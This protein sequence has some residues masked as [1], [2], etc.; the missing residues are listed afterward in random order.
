MLAGVIMPLIWVC[1]GSSVFGVGWLQLAYPWNGLVAGD[2]KWLPLDSSRDAANVQAGSHGCEQLVWCLTVLN[3]LWSKGLA[4]LPSR[5]GSES[6]LVQM[7]GG[8][9]PQFSP[10]ALGLSCLTVY[11][12]TLVQS[13]SWIE[14]WTR[15][16]DAVAPYRR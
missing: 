8:T 16:R 1:W 3:S 14:V 9:Q 5:L 2:D 12:L 4:Y 10:R 13:L 6:W 7:L 15:A 11:G